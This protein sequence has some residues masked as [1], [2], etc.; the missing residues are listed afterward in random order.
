MKEKNKKNSNLPMIF[1]ILDGW[2]ITKPSK[3]NAITLAKTPTL[4]GLVKKYPYTTFRSWSV[5][6]LATETGRE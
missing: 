3:G 5:C 2:G 4:N 1:I 6:R